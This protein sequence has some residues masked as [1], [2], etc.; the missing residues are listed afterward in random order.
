MK[1]VREEI[2]DKAKKGD[3]FR[4]VQQ[5]NERPNHYAVFFESGYA[6]SSIIRRRV[7]RPRQDINLDKVSQVPRGS[8]TDNLMKKTGCFVFDTLLNGEPV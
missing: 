5:R 2:Y 6:K 3:N 4:F 1:A 7:Q 8:A